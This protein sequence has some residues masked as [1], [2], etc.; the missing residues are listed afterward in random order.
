MGPCS[1]RAAF[2]QI[3]NNLEAEVVS[4]LKPVRC[5]VAAS[6]TG[7]NNMSLWTFMSCVHQVLITVG[8][9]PERLIK[10]IVWLHRTVMGV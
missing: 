2:G 10:F 7:L 8:S 4:N 5:L 1:H 6:K 3:A 9:V